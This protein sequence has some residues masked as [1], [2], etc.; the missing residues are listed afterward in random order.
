MKLNP[1][2]IL[3]GHAKEAIELYK[4]ALGA[5]VITLFTYG[6][7]PEQTSEEINDLVAFANLKIGKTVLMI[8][9]NGDPKSNSIYQ[10]NQVTICITP[11]DADGAQKVFDA[12]KQEGQIIFPLEK[13]SFS[14]AYSNVID[15]FGI[16]FHIFTEGDL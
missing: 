12:L 6:D 5:E 10:G 8:A 4:Q 11:E 16:T 14:P 2:I 1:F 9:D 7:M 3:N 13:T 15:K